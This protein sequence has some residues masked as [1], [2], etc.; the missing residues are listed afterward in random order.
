MMRA[1]TLSDSASAGRTER[2][3][4]ARP[5]FLPSRGIIIIAV[6]AASSI[7]FTYAGGRYLEKRASNATV[8]ALVA[9]EDVAVDPVYGSSEVV[10]ARLHFLL[11]RDRLDEAQS[12]LDEAV[13]HMKPAAQADALYNLANARIRLAFHA[14]EKRDLDHA[15]PLVRLAKDDYRKALGVRPENWDYKYNLDVAMRLVRD[16]PQPDFSEDEDA[17]GESKRVWT[18]LPGIPRGLP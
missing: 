3:S 17:E 18:D 5:R 9:G 2:L 10:M 8:R 16:F 7:A 15:I 1:T 13:P 14:I 11:F 4:G 6:L 12:L